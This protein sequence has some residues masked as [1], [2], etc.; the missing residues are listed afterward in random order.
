MESQSHERVGSAQNIR[1]P[2]DYHK[3]DALDLRIRHLL[4]CAE[5]T[6]IESGRLMKLRPELR[7]TDHKLARVLHGRPLPATTL[8]P[9]FPDDYQFP[10]SEAFGAPAVLCWAGWV[11][12]VRE[13]VEKLERRYFV[14][15]D[16]TSN[17]ASG[18]EDDI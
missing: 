8:R 10:G 9:D 3:T 7:R 15:L 18:E 17:V 6:E 13:H 2:L 5:L 16:G 14:D 1:I 12:R 11:H 4:A